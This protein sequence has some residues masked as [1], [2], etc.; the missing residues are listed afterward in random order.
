M[1]P[2]T[3]GPDD[4]VEISLDTR[5]YVPRGASRRDPRP[6]ILMTH[7]FGLT[8][9]GDEVV[10]TAQ[11]LA[12]HGYLVLTW[13]SS[14]FGESGGCITLQSAD[15]DVKGAMQLVDTLLEPRDDVLRDRRGL[16]L[17]T[18]GGS[19]GGG[20]QLPLAAA[21]HRIRATVPGRTWNS[22]R[23]SLD[24]N[25]LVADGDPT[26][27]DH[28]RQ[29]QGVFKQEWTSLFF[30]SGTSGAPQGDGGCAEAKQ[31]SGDPAE[32]AASGA[33]AA[34]YLETC[35]IFG[36][37]SSTGDSDAQ[38]RDFI[39]RA[40]ASTFLDDVRAATLLVQGQ[41][42]T[43]FNLN[44]A[45]ATY[46]ALKRRGVPVAMTWNSGGHG[47]YS[48]RPGE[49]EAYDGTPRT[50]R[51]MDA[52]YLPRRQLQW[53][54]HWLL[55]RGGRGPGFTW[56]EDWKTYDGSGPADEQYGAARRFPLPGRTTLALGDAPATLLNPAGGLPA[57]YSE[58][59]NFTGPDSEPSLGDLPPTEVEGQH[60]DFDS[61]PLARAADV[62]GI[63]SAR[64]ALSHV[65]GQDL[66]LFL[67]VYDVAPDG[68]AELVHR[69]ITPVRVP[70]ARLGE[71][72][73]VRLLGFAHRFAAGHVVRLTAATTDLTSYGAK[74]ADVVT[75]DAAASTV[76]WPGRLR[77]E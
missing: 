70:D 47:G 19:Y 66:V 13:T 59:S 74:V 51:E 10:S 9:L 54:D 42:D 45:A 69:L 72:V 26:G 68:T 12:A 39:A 75:V 40:S 36:L 46:V 18:I 14:G 61:P 44:D 48:S 50:V 35:R 58:T 55:G 43:L 2:V 7:G 23:Y 62:V 63:P 16:V 57:A 76:T 49:C 52:C 11:F 4:D 28:D 67:K 20:I 24:P 34:F 30:A 73:E 60:A 32:I 77:F 38:A 17:G 6:A 1:V 64:L 65:N 29:E 22:L 53:L 5:L 56:F 33:C 27:L 8:K 21:D 37:L 25:N 31:A 71:P 15:W 3:V 41:S